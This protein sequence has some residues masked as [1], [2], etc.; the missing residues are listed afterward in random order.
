MWLYRVPSLRACTN[1]EYSH[2]SEAQRFRCS[3]RS[4]AQR[5]QCSHRSE[6]QRFRCSH[7]SEAQRFRCSHRSEAQKFQC[8]HRSE[9]Q[10]FQC[11]KVQMF[12]QSTMHSSSHTCMQHISL[13]P[14]FI[15]HFCWQQLNP[16]IHIHIFLKF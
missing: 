12:L 13:S 8:S 6:A 3:H 11:S 7:I 14:Y 9:A 5:F 2:S 1:E 4:E 15:E 16:P 10:R